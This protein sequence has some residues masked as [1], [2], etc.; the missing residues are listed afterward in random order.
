MTSEGLKDVVLT[1]S[2]MSYLDGDKGELVYHGYDINDLAH[3]TRFEELFH[4]LWEGEFPTRGE[5]AE[6]CDTLA[7]NRPINEETK[8]LARNL[9]EADLHPMAALRSLVSSLAAYDPEAEASPLD[10]DSNY[11][12][13]QRI[14][15]KIITLIATFD[16]YR[17]GLDAID[18][19]PELSHAANFLYM[20]NGEKPSEEAEEI[21]NTC[22]VLHAD[23]GFNA[24]TFA[25]RV[26]ASTLSDIYSA[27][28]SAIGALKGLIH[29]G[30]NTEVMRMLLEI[31][32]SGADPVEFVK[33]RLAAGEKVMGFGHAVYNTIDPRSPYL[34]EMCKQLG[35]E[36]DQLKWYEYSVA[37]EDF[38]REEK[39]IRCNVDFYSASV[40][41]LL[42]IPI[43][44][45]T[46][47]FAA[48][49]VVGWLGHVMEQLSD[50][51]LIRPRAKYVGPRNREFVSLSERE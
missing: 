21:F 7:E 17:R 13:A 51:T 24:S 48:S 15:A 32:A 14:A 25:A 12:K 39:G 42:G 40:Y 3:K 28:T 50:N 23:H 37:I 47:I 35:E 8:A 38:L 45:Y 43:D 29:G 1:E 49:R 36:K 30:A 18:P 5:F 34:R 20:L 2:E 44:L 27:I 31:D 4:L 10:Q 26:T 11:R 9:A 19:D 46:T 22:L 41:Y 33:E 6:T 16:R